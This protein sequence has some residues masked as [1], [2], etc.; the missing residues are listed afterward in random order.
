MLELWKSRN[1]RE[2]QSGCNF[3]G[4]FWKKIP[5][6]S[7]D[8]RNTRS[9]RIICIGRSIF[10]DVDVVGPEQ[11]CFCP[12]RDHDNEKAEALSSR[13]GLV[14]FPLHSSLNTW[15]TT[16]RKGF[17]SWVCPIVSSYHQPF[18]DHETLYKFGRAVSILVRTLRVRRGEH[19]RHDPCGCQ[20][21]SWPGSC[22]LSIDSNF[23]H[24]TSTTVEFRI[25][26]SIS[27]DVV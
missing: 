12:L 19:G 11:F 26:W 3:I 10:V 18:R 8:L 5:N 9:E 15:R 16:T 4:T 14:L 27:A 22:V 1:M 21:F 17:V 25:W 23:S 2:L 7:C 20:L 24:R 6:D 13:R